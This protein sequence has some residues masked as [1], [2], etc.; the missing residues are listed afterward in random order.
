[1]S[2]F[3]DLIDGTLMQIDELLANSRADDALEVALM[4]RTQI[5]A[6]PERDIVFDRL[7]RLNQTIKKLQEVVKI[8]SNPEKEVLDRREHVTHRSGLLMIVFGLGSF[9]LPVPF[10]LSVLLFGLAIVLLRR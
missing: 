10:L 8:K 1:M 2:G 5:E 9:F 4:L 7:I 3:A 6:S